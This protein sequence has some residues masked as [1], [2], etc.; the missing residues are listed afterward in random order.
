MLNIS[1][2][3]FTLKIPPLNALLAP[4]NLR[5]RWIVELRGVTFS[6]VP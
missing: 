5:E 6:E 2:R 1:P 3:I 4:G